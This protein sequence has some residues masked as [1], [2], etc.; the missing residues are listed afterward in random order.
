L[1]LTNK[2]CD[3]GYE[4]K[5]NLIEE[6]QK[7]TIKQI[8]FLGGGGDRVKLKREMTLTKRKEIKRI[9]TKKNNIL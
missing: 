5:N 2:P 7:K 3:Q 8:F 9:E 1:R 4:I 6:E